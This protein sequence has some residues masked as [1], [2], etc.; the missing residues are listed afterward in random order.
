VN[1]LVPAARTLVTGA[2][3]C[4]RWTK[5]TPPATSDF[6]CRH[7]ADRGDAARVCRE[8]IVTTP[9]LGECISGPILYDETRLELGL[10]L[11]L[12]HLPQPSGVVV[13]SGT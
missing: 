12:Q 8:L 1:A 7:P 4:W 6:R 5:A 13:V 10:R 9:R 3:A 2:S 11:K